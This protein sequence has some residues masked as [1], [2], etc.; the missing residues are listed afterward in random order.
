[1]LVVLL[2]GT[3]AWAHATLVS[4]DPVKDAT[5]TKAPASV[6]LV[7]SEKLNPDFTTIAIS[8]AGRRRVAAAE[9]SV[10]GDI[11]SVTL[12]EPLGN[13]GYTVAYRVV[14]VDG[15]TVQG[16]YTFT[17]ADP[18]LPQ[19]AAATSAVA[20]PPPVGEGSGGGIPAPVLIGL[21]GLG[22]ALAVV[23]VVLWLTGRRRAAGRDRAAAAG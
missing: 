15:H 12:S 23:A 8:D 2:P 16:S 19:P 4:A 5:L 22:A 18:T 13:G 3:P 7:F 21:L 9:P 20:A 17:L 6:T 11:G 10:D 14:S 1:M